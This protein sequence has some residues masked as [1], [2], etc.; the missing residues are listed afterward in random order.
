MYRQFL[1]TLM[2]DI[3]KEPMEVSPTAHYSM[4]GVLVNPED[5]WAHV[6][7]LFA[8]GEV[9]GG[10]HGA[11]RLGGNS[12]AEIL[13]FGKRAG[14]A[15]ADRSMKMD[16]QMR[17]RKVI[18]QAHDKI[19][20][21][22][23]NGNEVARPL[24]RALRN[25]MWEHCGVVRDESRLNEGLDKIN[26]LK[27]TIQE[28]DVRPDS[29]GY[30]DLMLAFDL[31]GAVMSAEATVLSALQRRESRG[32]HQRSDYTNMDDSPVYNI[33]I[34]LSPDGKLSVDQQSA[35]PLS[36]ELQAV[37]KTTNEIKNYEGK[38]IE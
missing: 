31:E 3:S 19:N 30:E 8:A 37:V 29:E 4:G 7:G 18:Q 28:L 13:I 2:I 5:H 24:Q 27:E 38:L 6:D 32:A 1:D 22:L 36:E 20:S 33:H 9:A 21:L 34:E 17:S 16:V 14:R 11:N 26:E 10:L 25:V 23:R 15:A 35:D 12:L